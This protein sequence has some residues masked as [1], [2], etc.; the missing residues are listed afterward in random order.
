MKSGIVATPSDVMTK[1]TRML[2]RIMLLQTV[3]FV[4]FVAGGALVLRTAWENNHLPARCA[5]VSSSRT[6]PVIASCAHHS[7]RWPVILVLIGVV[8]LFVTGYVATRLAVR[9]LGEGAAAF[10][11]GGR[12]FT[13]PMSPRPAG[14]DMGAGLAGKPRHLPLEP[15]SHEDGSEPR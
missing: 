8:G 15:P 1:A 5:S 11:R 4:C 14:P 9:Y 12:R 2:K 6:A 13:G 7:Y 10:L 3:W